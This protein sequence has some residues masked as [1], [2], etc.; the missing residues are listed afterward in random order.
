MRPASRAA[1]AAKVGGV[2]DFLVT[3]GW[4]DR[5][6]AADAALDSAAAGRD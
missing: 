1:D 2:V 4:V 5:A 6:A 3:A